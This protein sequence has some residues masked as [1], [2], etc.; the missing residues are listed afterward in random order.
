MIPYKPVLRQNPT[1]DKV[2][3]L[4]AVSF[5]SDT[6]VL[7]VE[8]DYNNFLLVKNLLD[9][10]KINVIHVENGKDAIDI[11]KSDQK[12]SLI[13]MDIRMPVMDGLVAI[14]IIRQLFPAIPVIAVTAYATDK[15]RLRI[16]EAGFNDY[17]VKPI[18]KQILF[19]KME[20]YLAG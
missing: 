1:S 6:T 12:P 7:I 9:S 18:D 13:L 14:K 19:K 5:P 15:D 3:D 17:I 11:C 4:S 10:L 20:G 16:M 8:D 2:F